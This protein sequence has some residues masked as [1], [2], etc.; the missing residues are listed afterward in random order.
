MKQRIKQRLNKIYKGCGGWISCY[1]LVGVCG[2]KIKCHGRSR[3][4]FRKTK[5]C[6]RCSSKA[7]E[8]ENLLGM[9]K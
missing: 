7:K 8:L 6:S 5:L 2:Q 3:F 1:H 9:S 4:K